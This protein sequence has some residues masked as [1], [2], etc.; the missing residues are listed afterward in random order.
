MFHTGHI[1]SVAETASTPLKYRP[2]ENKVDAQRTILIENQYSTDRFQCDVTKQQQNKAA[3]IK[4]PLDDIAYH[5][6]LRTESLQISK[7]LKRGAPFGRVPSCA[8]AFVDRIQ[9]D[10]AM[11]KTHISTSPTFLAQQRL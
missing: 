11:T 5:K 8:S 6:R 4:S 2:I 1:R 9:H 3:P 10:T 7:S